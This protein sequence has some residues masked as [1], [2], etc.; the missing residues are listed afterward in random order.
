MHKMSILSPQGLIKVLAVLVFS[1]GLVTLGPTKSSYSQDKSLVIAAVTTPK[2]FDPDVWVPGMIESVVNVYEGLTRYGRKRDADGRL[3]IDSTVIEGHFAE[4]WKVSEDGL[5]YTFK[6]REGVKS[7]YGNELTA[8]DVVWG[9]EKSKPQKRTGAFLIRVARI[10]NVEALS[11]YEVRYTL[12]APNRIFLKVLAIYS[13]SLYDS[14][15][16]KKHVTAEDPWAL[17]WLSANTAG[18]GAYHVSSLR[19]GE[20]AVFVAN[21][22]YYF[23]KP[24]YERIVYREV[25]SPASRAALIKAGQVQWAQAIPT[26]QLADLI[27]DP[28]VK[29]ESDPGTGSVKIIMHAKMEPF[30]DVRVRRAVAFAVDY[31]AINEA[32]F[33][34]LGSLTTSAIAPAFEGAIDVYKSEYNPEKAKALLAEAGHANGI[35]VTFEYADNWWWEEAVAIQLKESAAKAGIRVTLKRIPSTEMNARRGPGQ[36]T[37][38]FF[39]LL[40]NSF[41][42]DPAY[43]LAL[44][45]HTKGTQNMGDYDIPEFD[46]LIDDMVVERDYDKWI[47]MVAQSQRDYNDQARQVDVLYPGVFEVM[48]PCVTG[49]QWRPVNYPHW[50]DLT[51]EK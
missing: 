46:K 15:E 12:S 9:Y 25:P 36:R 34:G 28:N 14:T 11:K 35:D 39:P 7:P 22:N 5:E 27:E 30:N 6:L 49:W 29:V 48:A 50:A 26:L 33:K 3:I 31:E 1:L 16:V 41:V 40:T 8:D 24:Y 44:F 32:V 42:L 19:P 23:D 38:A 13:P 4:S 21:P 43:A 37:V 17:K 20:G 45:A 2:G 51:C 18:F 10:A 47:E